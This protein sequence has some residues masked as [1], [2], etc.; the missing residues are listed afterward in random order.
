MSI[1]TEICLEDHW[2]LAQTRTDYSRNLRK[3]TV[4]YFDITCFRLNRLNC[5]SVELEQACTY[6][7]ISFSNSR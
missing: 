1:S 5:Y 3:R 2:N 6:A 7:S 4:A